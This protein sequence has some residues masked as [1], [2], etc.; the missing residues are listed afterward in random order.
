MVLNRT[1]NQLNE[2]LG[3]SANEIASFIIIFGIVFIA[4]GLG[5]FLL[6]GSLSQDYRTFANT[7]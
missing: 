2:T 6:F 4:F 7:L 1:L 5:G 3:N